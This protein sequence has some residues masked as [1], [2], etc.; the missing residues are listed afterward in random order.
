MSIPALKPH[1]PSRPT[2]VPAAPPVALPAAGARTEFLRRAAQYDLDP[3]GTVERGP[4]VVDTDTYSA[5][6]DGTAVDLSPRQIELLGVFLS[7]PDRVWSREMLHWI[8][9]GDTTPSRRVDVQLCR[10]RTKVGL[11]LF[12]NIRDRGWTLQLA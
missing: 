10:I 5:S 6:V 11:D 8:C 3:S 4:L 1:L 9:W 7:A 12:R 2:L